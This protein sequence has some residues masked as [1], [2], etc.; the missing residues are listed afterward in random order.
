LRSR[1][2][3]GAS[4]VTL[5]LMRIGILSDS[6]GR[7]DTTRRAVSQLL[8]HGA[9]MLL[10]LGDIE[11]EAV[12][13]ELVGHNARIIFGNCDWDERGLTRYAEHVGVA[14]DHPLGRLTIG[15][16]SIAYTHGHLETAMSQA[17]AE[18]PDYLLHGHSHAV[19][20][21][22]LDGTRIIN[23]GALFRAVR[24]TAAV[25]DVSSGKL[26]ILDLGKEQ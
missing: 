1:E 6:H 18:K 25:L 8:E 11:T 4:G 14:V 10:H 15:G 22:V 9:E 5:A 20:D 2:Q 17:L 26:L 13:D 21:E 7:A 16:R 3:E 23:P 12:I 24:Y 19:R